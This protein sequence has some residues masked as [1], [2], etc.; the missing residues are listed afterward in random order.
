MK[1]ED[2]QLHLHQSIDFHSLRTLMIGLFCYII[3][4]LQLQKQ[5]SSQHILN[6]RIHLQNSWEKFIC[7]QQEKSKNLQ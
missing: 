5:P 4:N 3:I 2:R 6:P 7:Y 1:F